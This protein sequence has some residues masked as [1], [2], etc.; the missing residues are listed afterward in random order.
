MNSD[1]LVGFG[2]QLS[3]HM[4]YLCLMRLRACENP[5][6][7]HILEAVLSRPSQQTP[8]ATQ[9]EGRPMAATRVSVA[10]QRL[11]ISRS[12]AGVPRTYRIVRSSRWGSRLAVLMRKLVP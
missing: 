8:T 7:L 5:R 2:G 11:A 10:R 9:R 1:H 4:L 3:L 6:P 12:A